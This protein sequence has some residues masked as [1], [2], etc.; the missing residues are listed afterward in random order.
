MHL[1]ISKYISKLT[2]NSKQLAK[3]LKTNQY[4]QVN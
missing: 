4:N 2:K 1:Y 3:H